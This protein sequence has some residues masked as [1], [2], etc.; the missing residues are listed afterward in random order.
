MI[1][2]ATHA[3]PQQTVT[4]NH[5]TSTRT[6]VD[7][8]SG[9]R[10]HGEAIITTPPMTD[11]PTIM[12]DGGGTAEVTTTTTTV[13]VEEK[14]GTMVVVVVVV[15]MLASH[16]GGGGTKKKVAAAAAETADTQADTR[17]AMIKARDGGD[18][19]IE[20]ATVTAVSRVVQ[21]TSA[22]TT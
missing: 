4:V 22:R 15:V 1:R 13:D 2:L 12:A 20:V 18:T 21:G 11:S 17:K 7:T 8:R 19:A 9:T 10:Q 14:M 5:A 16:G 3:A 6:A